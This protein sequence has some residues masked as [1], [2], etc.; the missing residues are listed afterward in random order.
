M[1]ANRFS[2]CGFSSFGRASPCQGEGG[3]FEPRNPL[4][5]RHHS[6]V[7]RQRSAKPLRPGSNPGGASKTKSTSYEVLFV[8][9]RCVPQAERDVHFVRDVSFGSDVRFARE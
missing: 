7:V 2:L 5:I 9:E 4:Q 8:L 3:G 6:Q 1:G